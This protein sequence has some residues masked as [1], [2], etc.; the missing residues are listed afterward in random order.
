MP[1]DV[2]AFDGMACDRQLAPVKHDLILHF[3]CTL[4]EFKEKLF[5]IIGHERLNAGGVVYFAYPKKGNKRYGEYIGRD[6]F[7]TVIDMNDEG[8]VAQSP[9]KFNKMVSFDET[10]TV[11]GLKHEIRRKGSSRPS[12]CVSAYV[13][14]L[15]DLV[16]LLESH[17]HALDFFN[18]L[19]PGY[20]RGW[21]RYVF[22]VKSEATL[23][24]HFNEMLDILNKGYK[25]IDLYR[26]DAR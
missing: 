9:V 15:P 26:K 5:D 25:S 3:I 18:R 2:D 10:F 6:D 17:P 19:T 22:A 11:I 14:K 20:Q 24:R 7:F 23:Q 13:D 12:Q 16:K 1:R 8:Y 4:E 21:A